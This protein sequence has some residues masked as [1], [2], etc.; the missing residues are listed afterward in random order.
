MG[1]EA[2]ELR[3]AITDLRGVGVDILTLGQYLRPSARHLPVVRW[4]TPDEFADLGAYAESLGFA[5]VEAGPARPVE[6]PREARGARPPTRK[7]RS[8]R[9]IWRRSATQSAPVDAHGGRVGAGTRGV[10]HH[11]A[12]LSGAP[13]LDDG[14]TACR[15]HEGIRAVLDRKPARV[16]REP[17]GDPRAARAA[18]A[19]P[20]DRTGGAGR[21]VLGERLA[22]RTGFGGALHVPGAH[23]TRRSTSRSA[24]ETRRSSPGGRSRTT[25]CARGSRRSIRSPAPR[26][27]RCATRSIR[28]RQRRSTSPSTTAS[29]PATSSSST[30]RIVACRTRMRP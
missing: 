16:P 4:W 19:H 25:G 1:E 21:A 18:P 22:A 30:T 29:T 5:H 23:A 28:C 24:P 20:D 13:T 17:A 2:G 7:S 9:V 3:A 12:R 14:G 15:S 6:L 10:P 11:R 27:T 26:S 8:A